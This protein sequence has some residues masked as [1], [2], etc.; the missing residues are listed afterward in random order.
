MAMRS[1]LDFTP[2]YRSSI[3]FDR[4]FN[5]LNNA[6][7]LHAVD[8]WP[9][10]D[11]IK[12]GE[13]EYR[14]TMAVAGFAENNLDIQQERNV[15]VVKGS[16]NQPQPGEYLHRGIAAQPFE[17]RFELAGHVTVEN[18]T[19]KNGLLTIALKREVPEALKPRRIAIGAVSADANGQRQIE[20]EKKVA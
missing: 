1:E 5:L 10:Y 19:M 11:I 15:L 17:R 8:N 16:E 6:Q 13:D 18:A 12:T 3:G 2:L 14:I 20:S 9:P 4:V 7:R